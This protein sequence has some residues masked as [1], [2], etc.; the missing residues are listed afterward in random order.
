MMKMRWQNTS[1]R[2][3]VII[4]VYNREELLKRAVISVLN[5]SFKDFEII[6]VDDGSSDNSA[7]VAKEFNIKV[8]SQPNR[9]V[10]AA[11]NAGIK[12]AKGE[13]IA[14]LDSDDEWKK[15]KLKIQ[16]EFFLKNLD[17]KI[18]QTDEIWIRDGKFLNKRKIHEKKEGKIFKESCKL[19]LISPSA[20]AIKKELFNEVGLFDEEF[21][22][23]EDYDLWLRITK[24]NLVGF[25]KDKMVIKYGGHKD[26]LSKRYY[27]MDR[28]RIK[29][30]LKHK[31]SI[32]ALL[33]AKNKC[34]ILLK[35]AY[36]HKNEKI[37]KE[38]EPIA[39][40]I[41]ESISSLHS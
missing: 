19:C 24:K 4:P 17:Y 37:I 40:E 11:R 26:Q 20:V 36:K 18:H 30:L 33:E 23:C 22:V 16:N 8:V 28:F 35:G 6:V 25:S 10:A 14:F 34:N 5:Q 27:A 13:I 41:D 7:K 31:D 21:T 2:F 12:E 9:G 38:F 3:S 15:D 29:A 1:V 32:D 39:K